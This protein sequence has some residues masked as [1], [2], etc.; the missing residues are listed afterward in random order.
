MLK[1]CLR[2]GCR[3]SRKS[4]LGPVIP[5][6]FQVLAR[7]GRIQSCTRGRMNAPWGSERRRG[8]VGWTGAQCRG[9]VQVRAESPFMPPATARFTSD[10]SYGYLESHTRKAR[11]DADAPGTPGIC[12]DQRVKGGHRERGGRGIPRR[13]GR[14]AG[15]GRIRTVTVQPGGVDGKEI[16]TRVRIRRHA[17]WQ[18]STRARSWRCARPTKR[19]AARRHG[20]SCS[21]RPSSSLT[22]RRQI[23]GGMTRMRLRSTRPPKFCLESGCFW[24]HA[25]RLLCAGSYRRHLWATRAPN[26]EFQAGVR[27]WRYCGL[28]GLEAKSFMNVSTVRYL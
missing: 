5:A 2:A 7:H 25:A 4:G 16:G 20:R 10:T 12:G 8:A 6:H 13:S 14:E 22:G 26:V 24:I 19:Q 3:A 1:M 23:R 17:Y 11:G 21:P 27:V 9:P 18:T 28:T 15:G